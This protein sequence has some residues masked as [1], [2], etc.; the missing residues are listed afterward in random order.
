MNYLNKLCYHFTHQISLDYQDNNISD[1]CAAPPRQTRELLN[2][3]SFSMAVNITINNVH[4]KTL[5]SKH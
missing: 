3:Q 4:R 1:A 2:V 5:N